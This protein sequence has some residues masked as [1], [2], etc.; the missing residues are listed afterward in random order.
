MQSGHSQD[1]RLPIDTSGVTAPVR[2]PR[3]IIVGR[4]A[5]KVLRSTR[6]IRYASP[7][8]RSA[9]AAE[10][11]APGIWK[12]GLDTSFRGHYPDEPMCFFMT[13]DD[14][15]SA[16]ITELGLFALK[17]PNAS[18]CGLIFSSHTYHREVPLAMDGSSSRM[19]YFFPYLGHNG[20]VPYMGM[21][22]PSMPLPASS[23][24]LVIEK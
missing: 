18:R 24:I 6:K 3:H 12:L 10:T 9:V 5:G 20:L 1:F 2:L 21:W 13:A 15:R 19:Q 7:W 17:Y 8:A 4:D 22:D 14:A 23:H 16:T 11:V